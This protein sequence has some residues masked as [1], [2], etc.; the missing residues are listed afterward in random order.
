M[1]SLNSI[2]S[3]VILLKFRKFACSIGFSNINKI[4][5]SITSNKMFINLKMFINI[6]ILLCLQYYTFS[7]YLKSNSNRILLKNKNSR[8]LQTKL[9]ISSN[10]HGIYNIE[11]QNGK[12]KLSFMINNKPMSFET[13]QIGRQAGGA[14][15]TRSCDT[16]VYA[17]ACAE[18]SF[19]Q[20]DFAP[21]RVDF[22]ARYSAVGQTIG[23]FHR[24]DSRGDDN[25][26]LVARL[27]DRPIRPMIHEGWQHETQLLSWVLSYDKQN[28]YEPLAICASS[29]A[30]AISEVPFAKPI[31]GV[32]VGM[33]GDELIVNPTKDQMKNSTLQLTIAG[34]KDGILMIEGFG[35]FIPEEQFIKALKLGHEAIGIICDGISLFQ[36]ICGKSKRMDTLRILP[37]QLIDEMDQEF[38]LK[39]TE[40]LSIGDKHK[41]GAAVGSIEEQIMSQFTSEGLQTIVNKDKVDENTEDIVALVDEAELIPIT[42]ESVLVEDEASEL[43]AST[44]LTH[45]PIRAGYNSIDVKVAMKKLLVR[46]LR[47]KILHTGKRSD[48]RGVSEVRPIDILIDLL[49]GAHGSSLFTRYCHLH[50]INYINVIS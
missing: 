22:F 50:L 14:V 42:E 21:L 10:D 30:L 46:V 43:L 13:G 20:V 19:Q 7:L 8:N 33:I 16:I 41:R 40:A 2:D 47:R 1:Y 37:T 48:G 11:S 15:M 44:G 24:R 17:T 26:I 38:G 29:A 36:Q 25:E 49:P 39:L 35:D 45:P 27:I 32:E 31:A 34:T 6:Y 4:I 12:H 5:I 9:D 28:S 18:H 23:A 3:V